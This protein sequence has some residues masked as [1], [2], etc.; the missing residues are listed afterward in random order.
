M[1]NWFETARFGMFI[2]WGIVSQRGWELSWPLV[3]GLGAL[4]VGQ[5]VSIADYYAT[6]KTFNPVN[7][8]PRHWARLA[9]R[10]EMQ[11]AVLTTKHHD[12]FAMFHTR[13]SDFSIE[14]TPYAKD[15]VRGFADAFRAEGLRVG[16]YFSLCDWHHPDY[17]ALTDADRPYKWGTWRRSTPQAWG[18]FLQSMFAQ[19]RELLSNY[20]KIDL[21]WFD[22]GWER[23]P[24]EWKAAEFERMI[25]SIQP[26]ILINDRLPGFGDFR[27]PEQAVP[28]IAPAEP[29]E[30][31]LTINHSWGYNPR[32]RDLKSSR[33]LVHTLCEVAGKG[34]NLLLNVSPTGDGSLPQ[35]Q[36]QRLEEIAAWM[37]RNGESIGGTLPG[38]EPWQ[39]YGPSTRRGNRVYLHLLMRP[40]ET[41]SVRGV[42]IKKVKTVRALSP[43][44]ELKFTT[45]CAAA[46][47][48]FNPDPVG[49]LTIEVP[50]RVLDPLAT[51]IAVD[52]E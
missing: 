19:M 40:Y 7:Y 32:D 45:S 2:H 39:F 5:S 29:W 51:V 24:E 42:R 38:L 31:C 43:V 33:A 13:T 16:F 46:D 1:S 4:P 15:I 21:L 10:A 30:T 41:V 12:G 28:P 18:R 17:P 44:T 26:E 50:E 23:T 25:R 9:K 27:T 20:G 3:G 48:I 34:G 6:A 22:G 36:V 14:H 52:F 11:Y 35:E 37:Q 47:M 8:D 49:E